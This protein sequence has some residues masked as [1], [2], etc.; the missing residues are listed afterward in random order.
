MIINRILFT[1]MLLISY[2][3][4][5][6]QNMENTIHV[7]PLN[8]SSIKKWRSDI[9]T[10]ATWSGYKNGNLWTANNNTGKEK[11]DCYLN[12]TEIGAGIDFYKDYGF[13]FESNIG[14]TYG[15]LAYTRSLFPESNVG[16]HWITLDANLSHTQL[17]GLFYAGV[18]T[19]LFVGSEI[20]NN[21][22]YS[23]EGFYNDCFNSVTFFPYFGFRLRL[24]YIKI[25]ARI[26][27]QV[28]P[29]LNANKLAYH[30]MHKSY[31]NNLYFEVRL[32]VKLFSTSNPSRP[33]NTLFSNL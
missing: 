6:A 1:L 13:L 8:A 11:S 29:Y 5:I 19:S 28:V 30:N 23:F 32:G 17:N 14:Y 16:S 7:D 26:G 27:D 25:D 12:F 20:N 3:N 4:L 31:V 15:S 18:K 21:D 33:I 9:Y 22:N 24:Q 2:V 10:F